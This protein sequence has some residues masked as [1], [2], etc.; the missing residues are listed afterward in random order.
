VVIT[1]VE[2]ERLADGETDARRA[3]LTEVAAGLR[4]LVLAIASTGV[5]VAVTTAALL[6]LTTASMIGLASMLWKLSA[7]QPP[8]WRDGGRSIRDRASVTQATM[9][10]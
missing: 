4:A 8:S 7:P 5:V 6:V 3:A 2:P 1:S 10:E 9:A